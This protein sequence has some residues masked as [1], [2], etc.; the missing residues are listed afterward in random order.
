M[1]INLLQQ[2]CKNFKPVQSC[3]TRCG[4]K[5]FSKETKCKKLHRKK[6]IVLNCIIL[7]RIASYCT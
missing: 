5:C 3:A 6:L 1:T 4:N 7:Y 2:R